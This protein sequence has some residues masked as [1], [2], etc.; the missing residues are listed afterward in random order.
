MSTDVD[1][2]AV[3]FDREDRVERSRDPIG[4]MGSASCGEADRG[5]ALETGVGALLDYD[6]V[7]VS[8]IE[9]TDLNSSTAAL[10][11]L[12]ERVVAPVLVGIQRLVRNSRV[13][14]LANPDR[15][16]AGRVEYF[17]GNRIMEFGTTVS[18][19]KV[20]TVGVKNHPGDAEVPIRIVTRYCSTDVDLSLV[21]ET[22]VELGGLGI[23]SSNASESMF[24]RWTIRREIQTNREVS[25]GVQA[26]PLIE[27]QVVYLGIHATASKVAVEAACQ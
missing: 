2:V 27:F 23:E 5:I 6:Q 14:I 17:T 13:R 26:A 1:V 9:V 19:V 15:G 22:G 3:D 12:V 11:S 7:A 20:L 21:A 18:N 24:D 25:A 4:L 10:G 16:D 8:D